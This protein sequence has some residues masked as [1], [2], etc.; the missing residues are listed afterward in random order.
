MEEVTASEP[1][2]RKSIARVR[3]KV[4]TAD[5]N[6]GA[7]AR[8]NVPLPATATTFGEHTPGTERQAPDRLEPQ[9]RPIVTSNTQPV[10]SSQVRQGGTREGTEV[11][12]E[13][14][15]VYSPV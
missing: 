9:L 10:D 8:V 12:A 11:D 2:A 13:S 14:P 3:P 15:P 6:I 1:I 5:P 7:Q 4:L